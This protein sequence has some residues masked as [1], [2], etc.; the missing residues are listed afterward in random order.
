MRWTGLKMLPVSITMFIAAAVGSKLSAK[1]SIRTIVR[2]GLSTTFVGVVG[3]LVTVKPDLA[4][5]MFATS[6]AILGWEWD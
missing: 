1:Y 6:M 3:L 4:D 2:V 5:G